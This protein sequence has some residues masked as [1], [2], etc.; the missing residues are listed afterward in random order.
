MV[1]Y[2]SGDIDDILFL[3]FMHAFDDVC[4]FI[5]LLLLTVSF[6]LVKKLQTV[7]HIDTT[8]HIKKDI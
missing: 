4:V 6:P 2:P 8:K 1:R 5:L 3:F 7:V